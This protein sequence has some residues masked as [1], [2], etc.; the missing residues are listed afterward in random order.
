MVHTRGNVIVDQIKI[1]DIHYE[2]ELGIGIKVK[3][4]TLPV[5]NG[6][7]WTW[8]AEIISNG[9]IIRY[10]VDETLSQYSANLY[11]YEVKML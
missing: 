6:V 8:D 11:D 10:L 2:Y 9:I 5:Q 4:L 1:G 7:I 3:V